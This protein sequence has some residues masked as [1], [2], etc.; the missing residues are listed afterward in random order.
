MK[1]KSAVIIPLILVLIAA[2]CAVTKYKGSMK[3]TWEENF[4]QPI[5]ADNSRWTK[6]PRGGSDWS[7]HMSDFD[8]C[9]GWR[10]GKLVLRGIRNTSLPGDTSK[11]LT[12]GVYTKNK[13]S[14]GLGRLEI[15]TRL[16]NATGAWPAFWMLGQGKRYPGGGE[17][18]IMEHL[19]DDTIVYQTVHSYYTIELNIKDNPDHSATAKMLPGKFNVYAVEKYRDSI[20]FYVNNKR[21]FAYPRIQTDKREQFPFADAEH[22]LLLDMQLGG[23]WVGEI[24]PEDLPVEMEIDWVR[25]YAFPPSQ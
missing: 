8:S 23:S 14:F 2:S 25:F 3:P 22:Y 19:N 15:S 18:D 12:G 16:G 7:R 10:D 20:V 11:Y 1:I 17:I 21:T 9:Y 6:I 24:D 13:V 4:D 5:D